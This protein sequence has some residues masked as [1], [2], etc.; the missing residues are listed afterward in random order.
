M[1]GTSGRAGF[2]TRCAFARQSGEWVAPRKLGYAWVIVFARCPC[3]RR[4]PLGLLSHVLE[5]S[6][7]S[8]SEGVAGC[9]L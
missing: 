5:E 6:W 9:L 1:S 4:S 2:S 8:C 7:G 3:V